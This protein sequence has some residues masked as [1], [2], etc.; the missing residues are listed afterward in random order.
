MTSSPYAEH[1]QVFVIL[2]A[3]T[4]ASRERAPATAVALLKALWSA[5]AAEAEVAR[6]T[7]LNREPGN[8]Y[9][10]KAAR[11][12][13]QRARAGVPSAASTR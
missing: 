2:R 3:D 11:L 5:A 7:E 13:R 10:W 8:V 9:F 4:S 1:D 12:E 6:L